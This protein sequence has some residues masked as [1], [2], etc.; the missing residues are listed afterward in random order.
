MDFDGTKTYDESL[1]VVNYVFYTSPIH[2]PALL[3]GATHY[4]ADYVKPKWASVLKKVATID[5]HIFYK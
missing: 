4:H 2:L 3:E 5:N 1:L